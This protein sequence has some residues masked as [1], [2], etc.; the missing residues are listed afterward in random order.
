M[1]G[2]EGRAGNDVSPTGLVDDCQSCQTEIFITR[3]ILDLN[4][5]R[6]PNTADVNVRPSDP[7]VAYNAFV[8]TGAGTTIAGVTGKTSL[9]VGDYLFLIANADP[10]VASN[11]MGV[12]NNATNSTVGANAYWGTNRK[13][14][15]VVGEN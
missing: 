4:E 15:R 5:N 3:G 12:A 6:L 13:Y 2:N 10:T 9:N 7:L 1:P 11:W 14:V 8:I